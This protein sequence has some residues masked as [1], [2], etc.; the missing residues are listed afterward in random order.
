MKVANYKNYQITIQDDKS[1][2]I[3][4]DGVAK[5]PVK[6]VLRELATAIDYPYDE[7]WITQAFGSNLV[8]FINDVMPSGTLNLVGNKKIDTIRRE[9]NAL[10][11]YLRIGI[12]DGS[13]RQLV[14]K[15]ESITALDGS[16][17]LKE[18]RT[19]ENP[20]ELSIYGNKKIKNI[21]NDFD[22]MYGLYVQICY[23]DAEGHR[24]YTSGSDDEMTVA[25][26]NEKCKKDGCKKG[27]WK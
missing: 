6:P 13:A 23:T 18:V 24:Y 27:A 17:T 2:D 8:N 7:S 3:S 16:K 22:T 12:F 19:K 9:F 1:V 20:G 25:S 26:F 4:V 15:G 21:E 5:K 10:Y 11:P 14:A